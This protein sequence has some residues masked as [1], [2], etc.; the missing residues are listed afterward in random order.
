MN[1]RL[2]LAVKFHCSVLVSVII[3][4]RQK[5]MPN[6]QPEYDETA[7][8]TLYWQFEDMI[9][10]SDGKVLVIFDDIVLVCNKDGKL[11]CRDH[12]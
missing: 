8:N 10:P 11:V 4:P 7:K 6:W 9:V 3:F 5:A 12:L 1:N 2:Y